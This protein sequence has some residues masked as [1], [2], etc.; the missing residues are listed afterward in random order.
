LLLSSAVLRDSS[1]LFSQ[2]PLTL[3]PALQDIHVDRGTWHSFFLTCHFYNI[4]G[5][6]SLVLSLRKNFYVFSPLPQAGLPSLARS[7]N[8]GN[9]KHLYDFDRHYLTRRSSHCN[10]D[11]RATLGCAGRLIESSRF[12]GSSNERRK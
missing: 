5:R 1:L 4:Q 8:R 7:I 6:Y 11:L 2:H 10:D 3:S 12:R 9:K